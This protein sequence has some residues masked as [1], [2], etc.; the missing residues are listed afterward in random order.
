MAVLPSR[1]LPL[2]QLCVAAL[3]V[4]AQAR[5]QDTVPRSSLE[6]QLI[7]GAS[8]PFPFCCMQPRHRCSSA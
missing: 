2:L 7:T 8:T 5:V 4:A 6:G 1:W 3:S